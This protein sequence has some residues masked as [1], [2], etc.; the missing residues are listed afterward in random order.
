MHTTF[1][2]SSSLVSVRSIPLKRLFSV[3]NDGMMSSDVGECSVLVLLD[4]N[5]AFH[6]VDR[7]TLIGRLRQW[8]GVSAW[9]HPGLVLLLS[10]TLEFF[11]DG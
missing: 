6:T 1:L 5:A 7:C 11:C 2:L 10:L 4:L 9:A 8:V 3:S